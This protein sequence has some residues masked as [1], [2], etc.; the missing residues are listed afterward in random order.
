MKLSKKVLYSLSIIILLLVATLLIIIAELN[1]KIDSA[2]DIILVI[3][4]NMTINQVLDKLNKQHI[5]TPNFFY[6]IVIKVYVKFTD[7]KLYAGVHKFSNNLTNAQLICQLLSSD[8]LQNVKVTFP[9]GITIY[10][11]A[12]ILQNKM[13]IDSAEFVYNC[14]DTNV[15]RLLGIEQNSLEGYLKPVTYT[16]YVD[17]NII[18][19]LKLL[20]KEQM[21]EINKYENDI[22]KTKYNKYQILTLASIIEAETPVIAERKRI[23]GVY[24]NR[25]KKNMLLQ[26]D[27][28]LQYIMKER[29]RRLFNYDLA[30]DSPYNTYKYIGL[31]PTPINN[32]SPSSIEA[33][34]FPEKNNYY[35]FVAAGDGSNTH[36]FSTNYA[37]HQQ[38]KSMY[39]KNI[40]KR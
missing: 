5:L 14:N 35:Y 30:I 31:P 32:P 18:D 4:K 27:P 15:C 38:Y 8:N 23:S 2:E 39:K 24:H 10:R 9:E 40:K 21:K 25:L 19:I 28:T 1:S 13:N 22:A 6:K 11:F 17:A 34:V 3:E 37:Q 33:A 12:S 16:F 7:T 36:N 26:A 20:V 29:K